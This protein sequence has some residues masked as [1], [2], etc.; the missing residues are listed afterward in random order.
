MFWGDE[1]EGGRFESKKL[2]PGLAR[3]PENST[4]LGIGKRAPTIDAAGEAAGGAS[5]E[6]SE[7]QAAW[8]RRLAPRHRRAVGT[9]FQRD[10]R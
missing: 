3:D 4:L 10:E 9:F 8:R 6:T 7:G 1:S 2:A 5:V